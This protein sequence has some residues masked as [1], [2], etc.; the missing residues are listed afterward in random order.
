MLFEGN[1]AYVFACL[2]VWNKRKRKPEQNP[3]IFL[4]CQN[5]NDHDTQKGKG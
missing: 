2:G 5:T 1:T 4:L 3:C